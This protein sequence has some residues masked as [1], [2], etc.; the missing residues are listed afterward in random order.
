MASSPTAFGILAFVVDED[1]PLAIGRG[2]FGRRVLELDGGDDVT[3]LWIER[4]EG[5]D[6]ATV[7]RPAEQ[8]SDLWSASD[9][10]ERV[11]SVYRPAHRQLHYLRPRTP[12]GSGR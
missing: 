6:R 5:A 12:L 8:R 7:I 10:D 1:V 4:G 2:T 11:S 3:G 9:I